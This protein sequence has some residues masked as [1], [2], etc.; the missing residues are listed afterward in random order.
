MFSIDL[1]F[2]FVVVLFVLRFFLIFFSIFSWFWEQPNKIHVDWAT[3]I[4]SCFL[5]N[6]MFF[7]SRGPMFYFNL[8]FMYVF[9]YLWF[10]LISWSSNIMYNLLFDWNPFVYD[11]VFIYG[12]EC[13]CINWFCFSGALENGKGE[14]VR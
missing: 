3:T 12:N 7:F 11:G 2:V 8:N 14:M 13:K 1:N 5:L 10:I 4:S 9:F 6:W